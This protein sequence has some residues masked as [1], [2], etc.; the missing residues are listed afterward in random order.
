MNKRMRFHIVHTGAARL[1]VGLFSESISEEEKHLISDYLWSIHD[2]TCITIYFED[3]IVL[4]TPDITSL[5][6]PE[7]MAI[8]KFGGILQERGVVV[9]CR[10]LDVMIR[11]ISLLWNRTRILFYTPVIPDADVESLMNNLR[12]AV[13]NDVRDVPVELLEQCHLVSLE[14]FHGRFIETAS[15]YRDTKYLRAKLD[16]F[17]EARSL[18]LHEVSDDVF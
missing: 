5:V 3:T 18:I 14:F 7:D 16:Q 13:S 17:A 12:A 9:N 8:H 6:A 15:K 11:L 2:S 4:R 10:S 1:Y